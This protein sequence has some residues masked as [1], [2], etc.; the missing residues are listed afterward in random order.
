MPGVSSW[1]GIAR[2]I[3][4]SPKIRTIRIKHSGIAK[5]LRLALVGPNEWVSTE[6]AL[7]KTGV[8]MWGIIKKIKVSDQLREKVARGGAV[9]DHAPP[10]V[11]PGFSYTDRNVRV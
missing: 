1:P 7:G 4:P 2:E 9:A 8:E 3:G 5:D 11:P 6:G 10:G